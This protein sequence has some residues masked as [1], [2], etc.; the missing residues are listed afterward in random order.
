[1]KY[2]DLISYGFSSSSSFE[3]SSILQ[4]LHHSHKFFKMVT[5][6]SLLIS[7]S[8]LS[9]CL[10]SVLPPVTSTTGESGILVLPVTEQSTTALSR[11]QVQ[12]GLNN[13]GS[14]YTISCKRDISDQIVTRLTVDNSHDGYTCAEYVFA[15][16]FGIFRDLG[17]SGLFHKPSTSSM[18]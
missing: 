17:Q 11:R 10:C 15:S 3:V 2:K 4:Y 1:M 8:L 5:I 16:G 18:Q 6:N 14:L 12:A 9:R 13:L 7:A